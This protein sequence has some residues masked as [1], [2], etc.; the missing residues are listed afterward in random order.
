MMCV[1]RISALT[2]Q[3]RDL[4]DAVMRLRQNRF[5]KT[6]GPKV[7]SSRDT[8]NNLYMRKDLLKFPSAP[9]LPPSFRPSTAPH[10]NNAHV[11]KMLTQLS[12][13]PKG[14]RALKHSIRREQQGEVVRSR[15]KTHRNNTNNNTNTGGNNKS[16]NNND[17][18]YRVATPPLRSP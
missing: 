16:N 15:K 14:R 7:S 18:N 12:G 3:L 4:E 2:A 1:K 10:W 6:R 9:R 8:L 13:G 11:N 5:P 17:D